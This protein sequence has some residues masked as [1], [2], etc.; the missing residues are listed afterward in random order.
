M[1]RL[2][3]RPELQALLPDVE[4]FYRAV[5]GAFRY[6]E[7]FSEEDLVRARALLAAGRE[8]AKAAASGRATWMEQRGP[9][10][11]GYVLEARRIDPA[12]WPV[13]ARGLDRR[14]SAARWRLDTWFHG[15]GEKLSEVNFVHQVSRSGGDFVRNERHHAAA[16]RPLS[17]TA[18]S[19]PGRWISGRRWRT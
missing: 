17:A 14:Q 8:R 7:F 11:L 10:A 18:A 13:P 4:I 16:L 5:D 19:S 9:T 12:L 15:R 6:D 3:A 2:R 1:K